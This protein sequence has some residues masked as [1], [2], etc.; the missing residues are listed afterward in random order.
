[1]RDMSSEA[2]TDARTNIRKTDTSHSMVL[3]NG[4]HLVSRLVLQRHLV[5]SYRFWQRPR[6]ACHLTRTTTWAANPRTVRIGTSSP[7]A[8]EAALPQW[9]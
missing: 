9:L 3:F 8:T 1:M 2:K 7:S 4:V 6:P 5:P